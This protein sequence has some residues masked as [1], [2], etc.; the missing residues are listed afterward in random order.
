MRGYCTGINMEEQK[1]PRE[2]EL[3]EIQAR[4]GIVVNLVKNS[5]TIDGLDKEIAAA[6]RELNDTT[7]VFIFHDS[8]AFQGSC[9]LRSLLRID[10]ALDTKVLFQGKK[11]VHKE[12]VKLLER[13]LA[14]VREL[15]HGI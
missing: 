3:S 11:D 1:D 15:N 10:K 13:K 6:E 7:E 12:C 9:H 5:V 4:L 14:L 2:V 8:S